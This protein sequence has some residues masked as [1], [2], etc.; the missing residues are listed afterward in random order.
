MADTAISGLTAFTAFAADDLLV[1]VDTSAAQTKKSS[2]ALFHELDRKVFANAATARVING[3]GATDTYLTGSNIAIPSGYPVVGT[4]YRM[5]FDVTKTA[6]GTATPIVRVRIG[7]AGST[8]DTAILTFTFGAGTAAIDTAIVEVFAQFRTV[9][10]S[11][12][13]VLVG[14]CRA[15]TNLTTTGWSNAVKALPAVSSGFNST[16]ASLIIGASYNGGT[17]AVHTVEH[18]A[19]E[20]I[21]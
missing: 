5:S 11:T 21:L 1:G 17:S 12:S 6:A 10:A 3:A 8:A 20:L 19:S 14:W 4:A 13:A 15:V 9:G 18:V 16:T 2:L 7:T